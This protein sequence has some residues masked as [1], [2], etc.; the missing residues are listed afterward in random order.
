VSETPT[1]PR[2][3][4]QALTRLLRPL[5]RL[6][7]R[8]GMSFGA[9]QALAK[10]AYVDV[11]L[12]EFSLPGKKPSISRV[13]I[14][15]G[16]TR[17][18]VQRLLA[19]PAEADTAGAER[20]N[21]ASRVLTGWVRDSDYNDPQGQPRAL[22]AEGDTSFA[23]LVRRHSGDMPARAVLD[24]LM[25]VGA[26]RRLDDGRVALVAR[27]YVPHA[28]VTDKLHI[29]GT[30]VADL[31]GTIDHNLVHGAAQPRFQRKVLYHAIPA[32]AAPA[33]HALAAAES[34]ALLLR[35]DR[36]LAAHDTAS[37][38]DARVR[39]GLGIHAVEEAVPARLA[40]ESHAP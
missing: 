33:F 4:E 23:T 38:T 6:M 16:L 26:V 2:A 14:L 5:C 24:E 30:D 40:T 22:P 17:K 9:F 35:L 12:T 21:R 19:E 29:L 13:S 31:I 10:R 8:H 36:W 7:L 18:E 20:Y 11:A 25:R 37:P 39:I 3:L 34:Q 15:S 27:A 1:L 28:S 32:E